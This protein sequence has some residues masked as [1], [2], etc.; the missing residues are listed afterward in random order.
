MRFYQC[1]DYADMSNRA[2]EFILRELRSKPR[3][4]ICTATGNSPL[5]TYHHLA[6]ACRNH[7]ELFE[8]LGVIKL[9]EWGGVS[10]DSPW[11]CEAF[12]QENILRPLHIKEEQYITFKGDAIDPLDECLRVDQLLRERGPI[13]ICILGLGKNGHLGFNEPGEYLIPSTHVVQLSGASKAHAMVSGLAVKPTYGLTLG[14]A[15][16]LQS[17]RILLLISGNGKRPAL[18]QLQ[19]KQLTTALPASL[20]WLHPEVHCFLDRSMD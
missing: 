16:I 15:T 10:L 17:R 6:V 18:E 7:P 4:Y 14:M 9:D 2:A 8:S 1:T 20:L 12:I 3:S 19:K 13:D 11:S 5:G